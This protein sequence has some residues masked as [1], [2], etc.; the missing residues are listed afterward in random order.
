[1]INAAKAKLEAAKN[2]LNG[3]NTNIE[4]LSELV[5]DSEMKNGYSYYYMQMQIKKKHM[6]KQ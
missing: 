1:M 3:K 6:I 5:K 4:E 2:A